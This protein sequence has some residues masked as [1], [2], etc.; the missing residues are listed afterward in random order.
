[1]VTEIHSKYSIIASCIP[2]MRPLVEA[3]AVGL[4]TNDI[5]IPEDDKSNPI[6]ENS[7]RI[8][9]VNPFALR[10]GS[11]TNLTR[12]PHARAGHK[13]MSAK[14][15]VFT[16]TISGGSNQVGH[17]VELEALESS[18]KYGSEERMVINQT[19]TTSVSSETPSLAT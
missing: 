13:S 17:G 10:K 14:Q 11:W 3:L 19:K 1:M 5:F 7:R 2:F 6:K 9:R 12:D 15:G 8:S 4:V 16:S 18:K